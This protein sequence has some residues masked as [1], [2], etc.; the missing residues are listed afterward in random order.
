MGILD[1]LTINVEEEKNWRRNVS[2]KS[3]PTVRDLGDFEAS[4]NLH[5]CTHHTIHLSF[6]DQ[7]NGDNFV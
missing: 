6:K 1:C 3:S 2:A 4:L 5:G 7:N